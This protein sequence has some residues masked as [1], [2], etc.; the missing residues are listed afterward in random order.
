MRSVVAEAATLG[1][2]VVPPRAGSSATH[3]RLVTTGPSG[4]RTTLYVDGAKP[5]SNGRADRAFATTLPGAVP[6]TV[7]VRF[8]FAGADPFEVLVASWRA[9]RAEG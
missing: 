7:D 6:T 2:D 8:P 1:Y 5:T 9:R 3:L 4:R